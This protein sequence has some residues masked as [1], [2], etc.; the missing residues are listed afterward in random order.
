MANQTMRNYVV[1]ASRSI[2]L[3][4]CGKTPSPTAQWMD[5]HI[6]APLS[7]LLYITSKAG[8]WAGGICELATI[9]G[10]SAHTDELPGPEEAEWRGEEP[11]AASSGAQA[12][13]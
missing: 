3:G 7:S 13:R 10:V 2:Y 12:E 5:V 11:L 4:L 8:T 1:C 6:I 9:P